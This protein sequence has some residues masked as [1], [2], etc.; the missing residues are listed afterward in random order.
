MINFLL[1]ERVLQE[2]PQLRMYHRMWLQISHV[3]LRSPAKNC[4]DGQTVGY[5][6]NPVC[7]KN[8][9]RDPEDANY[10]N[11]NEHQS[12]SFSLVPNWCQNCNAH[13][14]IIQHQQEQIILQ[15]SSIFSYSNSRSSS[16]FRSIVDSPCVSLVPEVILC[17]SSLACLSFDY[18]PKVGIMKIGFV[19][20]P[21][22]AQVAK[23]LRL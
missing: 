23:C 2:I 21:Y 19:S 22:F 15:E 1:L 8:Q 4:G 5:E 11:V 20:M 12:Q 16:L 10:Q 18:E 9:G 14:N 6:T 13:C 17:F 7:G 3:G